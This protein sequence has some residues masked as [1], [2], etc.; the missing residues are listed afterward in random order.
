M[1]SW[2]QNMKLEKT[3]NPQ[4]KK[5]HYN[6]KNTWIE[7]VKQYTNRYWGFPKAAGQI[8]S[9]HEIRTHPIS[10]VRTPFLSPKLTKHIKQLKNRS[11]GTSLDDSNPR[12]RSSSLI[13][14]KETPPREMTGTAPIQ[15]STQPIKTDTVSMPNSPV[16]SPKKTCTIQNFAFTSICW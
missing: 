6:Q 10:A 2:L 12:I 5:F 8:R 13:T 15:I 3:L 11:R 16:G 7:M 9:I 4:K 14:K 1:M